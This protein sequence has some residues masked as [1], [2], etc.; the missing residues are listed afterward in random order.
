MIEQRAL[1]IHGKLISY[2]V[3]I[4]F[5][6]RY[7]NCIGV[8]PGLDEFSLAEIDNAL[9]FYLIGLCAAIVSEI[10]QEKTDYIHLDLDSVSRYLMDKEVKPINPNEVP[11]R[12]SIGTKRFPVRS[13]FEALRYLIAN[14]EDIIIRPFPKWD[15]KFARGLN[16]IWSGFS[17]EDEIRSVV[18][19]LEN[20]ILEYTEFVNG[21][22][23]QISESSYLNPEV[24]IVYEYIP[25]S[26]GNE[27]SGPNL[28]EHHIKNPE[29]KLPKLS[30]QI[31]ES[32]DELIDLHDF[33]EIMLDG[34]QY[35]AISSSQ[36]RGDSFFG[37]TPVL[38]LIYKMLIADLSAQYG[39]NVLTQIL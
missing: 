17:E 4:G 10:A 12:F 27:F 8:E 14:N 3:L 32:E 7:H 33:P 24:A 36:G 15:P 37:T 1:P 35:Q 2:D 22:R 11:V 23:M 6:E 29:N 21:N 9:N 34:E 28:N 39:I 25:V 30:I 38:N 20:S 16:F 26:K 19:I 13:A 31:K 5:I 18:N